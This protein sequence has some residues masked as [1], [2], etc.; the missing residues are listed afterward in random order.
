[1]AH[2]RRG[3]MVHHRHGLDGLRYGDAGD[4]REGCRRGRRGNA[5]NYS[6]FV[7]AFPSNVRTFWGR[8]NVGGN[9]SNAWINGDIALEVAGHELGHNLGL[10]HS[11]NMDCGASP[12]GTNCTVDE[13]GDTLD[14][15][16]A[17]RGH[18][19][20][21]QKER[22]GWLTPS[23]IVT[24]NSSGTYALEPLAATEQRR[25][26][27]QD[28]EIDRSGQRA[29]HVLLRRAAP[30]RRLRQLHERLDERDDR[31][32]GPHRLGVRRQQFVSA[33][34][35][36]RDDV[37]VRPG[38]HRRAPFSDA[39][40]G[41]SLTTLSVGSAGSTVSVT[42]QPTAPTCTPAAP[43]VTVTQS[44][45]AAVAPAPPSATPSSS[46]TT[47]RPA[48][49]ARPSRSWLPSRAAGPLRSPPPCCRW[50]RALY[51]IDDAEP[52]IA[53]QR[54]SRCMRS[55]CERRMQASPFTCLL[56]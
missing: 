34:H 26:G 22:L 21:F 12:V 46:R 41:L 38:P 1:M 51:G 23:Q 33:G 49:T 14:L 17:T 27:P 47:T 48:A 32:R 15:M 24:V 53:D 6:R 42:L 5:P 18:F 37:V 19:N 31:R 10:Y 13:Y 29:A 11:R 50:L 16:G 9:P 8:G 28:P 30:G 25:Q 2:G 7:Y 4:A 44:T 39:A 3:R 20:A 56:G 54:V 45:T 55:R 35:D 40:A 43:R 36:A 52:D